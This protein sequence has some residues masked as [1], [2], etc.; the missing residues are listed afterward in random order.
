MGDA[1]A[2]AVYRDELIDLAAER[3]AEELLHAAQV[4]ESLLAD[5]GNESDRA[6]RLHMTFIEGAR[7]REDDGEPAAIVADAG[8]FEHGA[9]TR[10]FDIG[11]FGK[12]RVEVRGQDDVG[13][14]RLAGRTPITLPAASM[15]TSCNPSSSKSRLSSR[16]R[17]SS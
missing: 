1:E 13:M 3:F 6:G 17:T 12:D 9:F 14:R 10:H 7:H 4:A 5:I 16:P 2:E 8:A 15:R 11:A